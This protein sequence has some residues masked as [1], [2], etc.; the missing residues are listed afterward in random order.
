MDACVKNGH[1]GEPGD[2]AWNDLSHLNWAE[3]KVGSH[4][5]DHFDLAEIQ[6]SIH[7]CAAGR[8]TTDSLALVCF[9]LYP[10]MKRV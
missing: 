7:P 8:S 6:A 9:V 4:A 2:A 10:H 1:D 3:G 5:S